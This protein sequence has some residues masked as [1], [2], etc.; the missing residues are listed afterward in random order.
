MHS[1]LFSCVEC[2][3]VLASGRLAKAVLQIRYECAI[4]RLQVF[5][6]PASNVKC[7]E[8]GACRAELSLLERG[9]KI[10]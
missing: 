6:R 1:N 2:A 7:S 5:S 4:W 10:W 3:V 8:T 9:Y